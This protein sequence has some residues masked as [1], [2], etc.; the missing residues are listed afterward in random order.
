M[1]DQKIEIAIGREFPRKVIPLIDK[2]KRT[3]KIIVFD[4]GWYENEIGEKI[5]L[6]NN[7][8]IRAN[9]RG[10]EVKAA[11]HKRLI[12]EILKR[13]GIRVKRIESSKLLHV[14]LMLIDDEIVIIGSHNYTKNAFNINFEASLIVR[15]KETALKFLNYFEGFFY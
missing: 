11:V 6:F 2:T 12:A 13:Q 15:D 4:W 1:E 9:K 3:I 8:I 10:V 5:Q 7:A 14:K